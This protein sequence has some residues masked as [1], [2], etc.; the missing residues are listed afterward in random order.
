MEVKPENVLEALYQF[1]LH[2]FHGDRASTF[3]AEGSHAVAFD[4]T[5]DDEVKGRK[6][7]VAV[8]RD[9]MFAHPAPDLDPDGAGFLAVYPDPGMGRKSVAFEAELGHESN[10]GFLEVTQPFVKVL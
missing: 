6:V 9:P 8:Q 3:L 5:W 4:A 10:D 2:V 1:G 7:V